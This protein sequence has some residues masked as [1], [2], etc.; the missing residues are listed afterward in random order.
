MLL[1]FDYMSQHLKGIL[2]LV[3]YDKGKYWYK[4]VL[5]ISMLY[6]IDYCDISLP[7]NLSEDFSPIS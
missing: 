6:S 5:D 1:L 3:I 7:S 2:V 4:V